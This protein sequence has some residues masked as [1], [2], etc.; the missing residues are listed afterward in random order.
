MKNLVIYYS[1]QGN[2]EVVAKEVHKM[3]GGDLK[4][5]EEVKERKLQSFGLSAATAFFGLKSKL[6]PID[7][8][9]ASYDNI[10]LGGQVWAARTTPAINSF[11]SYAK[12]KD[13]KVYLFLTKADN[14]VP[15]K[16]IDSITQKVKNRGGTVV[17]SLSITTQMKTIITPEAIKDSVSNWVKIIL[18]SKP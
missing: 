10:F 17:D 4:R 2:T 13:K 6:K 12:L 7:L 15:Q 14:K 11:L 18:E 8:N 5:I 16:V 9:L 1:W 3:V